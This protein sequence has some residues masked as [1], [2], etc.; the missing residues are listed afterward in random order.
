MANYPCSPYGPIN[1]NVIKASIEQIKGLTLG[2]PNVSVPGTQAID[3]CGI[4]QNL[5]NQEI[6]AL[7]EYIC[8]INSQNALLAPI[9]ELIDFLEHPTAI[10]TWINN[11]ITTCLIPQYSAYIAY[12]EQAALLVAEVE[13]LLEAIVETEQNIKNCKITIPPIIPIIPFV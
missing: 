4:L 11:F 8:G 13:S 5:V 2:F 12:A 9:L 3:A 10:I 6:A 1:L 7:N